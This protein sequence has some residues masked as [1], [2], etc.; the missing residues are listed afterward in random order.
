[1]KPKHRRFLF[2]LIANMALVASSAHADDEQTLRQRWANVYADIAH[3]LRMYSAKA[4]T[5]EFTP[6]SSPLLNYANPVRNWQQHGS[7]FLWTTGGH[8]AAIGSV[9]SVE[10]RKDTTRRKVALE[11]HSLVED[12]V[13][14]E[15]DHETIWESREPGLS[16]KR[17]PLDIQ[18]A[19]SAPLRLSQ[20]RQL[21]RTVSAK[22]ETEESE[23]RL[24]PQPLYRY[25]ESATAVVDGALFG[26]VMGTDPELFALVEA[27][28]D[29]DRPGWYWAFA[30]F[31]HVG[32]T[33]K[34]SRQVVFECQHRRD[35][36]ALTKYFVHF[37]AEDRLA[38]LE[39]VRQETPE[40]KHGRRN[41]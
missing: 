21:M 17:C 11:F 24:M 37:K 19:S 2:A 36:I 5:R 39:E 12:N 32:L 33:A 40:S 25:P 22:I 34:S 26:F 7:V 38:L 15:K 10:D 23:L 35:A 9:W 4:E 16:W 13:R 14:C 6:V 8:P 18:P 41:P 20:M 3:S 31:T 29:G 1:M 30:R 27:R 28:R